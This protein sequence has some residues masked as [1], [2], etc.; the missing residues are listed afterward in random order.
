MAFHTVVQSPGPLL[1]MTLQVRRQSYGRRYRG[2]LVE[3]PDGDMYHLTL[4]PLAPVGHLSS[5]E[6]QAV[7]TCHAATHQ[8]WRKTDLNQNFPV[9]AALDPHQS[10]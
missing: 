5:P 3:Q 4:M 2:F 1:L 10:Q 9:F 8:E 7:R 6:Y